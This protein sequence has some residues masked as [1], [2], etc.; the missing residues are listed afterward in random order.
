MQAGIEGLIV[1]GGA[2]PY[3][4]GERDWLKVKHRD[5][6][7]VLC[8]AVIGPRER[9]QELVLG[10]PVGG[11]LRIVGRTSPL[12]TGAARTLGKILQSP[13][14]PHP[15]PEQVEPGAID[16]FNRSGRD[17]PKLTLVQPTVVEVSADVAMTGHSFR[18]AVRYLRARPETPMGEI[19]ERG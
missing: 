12:P 1:K 5:T 16:R 6:L 7:D 18:H 19:I 3:R 14:A 17:R 8:G 9:P 2:Q 11:V 15:W 10:L 4:G 13:V